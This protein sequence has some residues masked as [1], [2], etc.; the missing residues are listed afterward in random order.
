MILKLILLTSLLVSAPAAF[1]TLHGV[2]EGETNGPLPVRV[3]VNEEINLPEL[4]ERTGLSQDDLEELHLVVNRSKIF[5]KTSLN[6]LAQSTQRYLLEQEPKIVDDVSMEFVYSTTQFFIAYKNFPD[7]LND[8]VLRGLNMIKAATLVANNYYQYSLLSNELKRIDPTD[9]ENL[10]AVAMIF[11]SSISVWETHLDKWDKESESWVGSYSQYAYYFG[12]DVSDKIF[13]RCEG[14]KPNSKTVDSLKKL[15]EKE[16]QD[17]NQIN[18]AF[19]ALEAKRL[20]ILG[21]SNDVV[22]GKFDQLS[23]AKKKSL[24]DSLLKTLLMR[25]DSFIASLDTTS[26]Y[27]PPAKGPQDFQDKELSAQE[28]NS[29]L[30]NTVQ[31]KKRNQGAKKKGKPG[32]KKTFQKKSSTQSPEK[33]DL[34]NLPEPT[35]ASE[36]LEQSE[37]ETESE[38]ATTEPLTKTGPIEK[39]QPSVRARDRKQ[40][41][42]TAK[43]LNRSKVDIVQTPKANSTSVSVD[44][45]C[46]HLPLPIVEL[47][48]NQFHNREGDL[49]KK[50]K[51]EFFQ[52]TGWGSIDVFS[53]TLEKYDWIMNTDHR[54]STVS[55]SMPKK[56]ISFMLPNLNEEKLNEKAAQKGIGFHGDHGTRNS[57]DTMGPIA[58][59]YIV[60]ALEQNGFTLEFLEKYYKKHFLDKK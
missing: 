47:F 24:F 26:Q 41:K 13:S 27:Q 40:Q 2:I 25:F 48:L 50:K 51:G 10:M 23:T 58:N 37:T 57:K 30:Q 8:S 43:A 55:F 22:N 44:R 54:S 42:D 60:S 28:S 3:R 59:H 52:P 6:I 7:A 39:K 46:E 11:R 1:A 36:S 38:P 14:A 35:E 34:S 33:P 16:D 45:Y 17:S 15:I 18:S 19:F 31:P 32:G 49:H 53:K 20:S 29:W 5:F 56:L 9:C 21:V 12:R 4:P